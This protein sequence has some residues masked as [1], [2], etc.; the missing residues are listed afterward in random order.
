MPCPGKGNGTHGAVPEFDEAG[1]GGIVFGYVQELIDFPDE[2]RVFGDPAQYFRPTHLDLG[3]AVDKDGSGPCLTDAP[4][5]RT[6][7][8][9]YASGRRYCLE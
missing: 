7:W 4:T 8:F 6:V 1:L 9:V 3:S 2:S 5:M